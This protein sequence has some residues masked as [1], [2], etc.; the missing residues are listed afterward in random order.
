MEWKNFIDESEEFEAIFEYKSVTKKI[1]VLAATNKRA[2]IFKKSYNDY[3]FVSSH[4]AI[5]QIEYG[6][7]RM[8]YWLWAYLI[9]IFS[10]SLYDVVTSPNPLNVTLFVLSLIHI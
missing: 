1:K 5:S 4:K 3:K 9:L 10:Y 7:W 8:P 6:R 2:F